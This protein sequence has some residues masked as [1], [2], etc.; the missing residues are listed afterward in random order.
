MLT[1]KK[2]LRR[3][4]ALARL[5]V[6]LKSGVKPACHLVNGKKVTFNDITEPLTDSDIFRIKKEIS[7]LES[8]IPKALL[9]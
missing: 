6:Q 2:Q 1:T 8:R 9:K 4:S 7:T 3:K 5:I